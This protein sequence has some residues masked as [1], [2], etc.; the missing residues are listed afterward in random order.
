M[1]QLT[2]RASTLAAQ[3]VTSALDGGTLEFVTT[4]GVVA[5]R[6]GFGTPA[7]GAVV[8]GRAE[9]N[10]FTPDLSPTGGT[11]V[12]F[13]AR[14]ATSRALLRGTVGNFAGDIRLADNNIVPDLPFTLDLFVYLQT[15]T[16][17]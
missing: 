8:N 15:Q 5:A 7:F 16:P 3:A 14:D 6:L 9:A 4:S 10:A 17:V 2:N 13:V 12:T 1:A 11:A